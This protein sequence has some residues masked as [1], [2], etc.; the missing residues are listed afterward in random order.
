MCSFQCLYHQPVFQKKQFLY[1]RRLSASL[2][3]Y[4]TGDL[5]LFGLFDRNIGLTTKCAMVKVSENV[6]E[7]PLPQ[8]PVDMTKTKSKTFVE[9]VNKKQ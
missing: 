2:L 3:W 5:N 4:L 8:T 1:L 9:C 6:I 7:E